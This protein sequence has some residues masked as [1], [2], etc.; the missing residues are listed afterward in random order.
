[1][2]NPCIG[3]DPL[4]PC[5]DGDAC[6]Y[7]DTPKTKGWPIPAAQGEPVA[8]DDLPPLP[9]PEDGPMLRNHPY[10]TADQMRDVQREAYEV[11]KRAAL[12]AAAPAQPAEHSPEF[13]RMWDE[14]PVTEPAPP[15]PALTD[16]QIDEAWISAQD[17]FDAA[18]PKY[19]RGH[20]EWRGRVEAAIKSLVES[21][22]IAGGA[23]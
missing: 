6:H 18:M 12:D 3:N 4:C 1:M 11:G 2:N 13:R 19:L 7:K 5:Q 15:Q 16:E 20:S 21:G 17:A 23:K 10:F 9:E 14:S 8:P 22:V